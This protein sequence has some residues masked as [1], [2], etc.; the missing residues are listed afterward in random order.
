MKIGL[1]SLLVL[2]LHPIRDDGE[3]LVLAGDVVIAGDREAVEPMGGDGAIDR[4]VRASGVELAL[5]LEGEVPEPGVDS[6][7][8]LLVA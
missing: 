6:L 7:R 1:G 8:H 3:H 2:D 4:H 5:L